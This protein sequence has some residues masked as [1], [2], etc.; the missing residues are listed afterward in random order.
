MMAKLVKFKDGRFVCWSRVD[1]DNGEPIWISVARSGVLVKKSR[2]GLFGEKLYKA[3]AYDANRTVVALCTIC[4]QEGIPEEYDLLNN[5]TNPLLRAFTLEAMVSESA[6][7]LS[8]KLNSDLCTLANERSLQSFEKLKKF[9]NGVLEPI[10]EQA[11]KSPSDIENL[12]K[13]NQEKIINKQDADNIFSLNVREWDAYAKQITF[14]IGWENNFSE[15]HCVA[16]FDQST[17]MG[18]SIQPLFEDN[19][20]PPTTIVVGSYYPLDTFPIFTDD[21][22]NTIEKEAAD[23]LGPEY[24]VS[25]IFIK[26]PPFEIIELRISKK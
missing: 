1:L 9:G 2:G 17:H 21:I 23:D 3:N 12:L 5:M 20:S 11:N 6:S 8:I 13:H 16:A 26:T 25:A 15:Y 7:Q 10:N 14:P 24:S 19:S 18:L 22:K 4:L